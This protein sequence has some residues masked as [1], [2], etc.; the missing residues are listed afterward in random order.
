MVKRLV[1]IDRLK[2]YVD[3]LKIND[4]IEFGEGFNCG[5]EAA[6]CA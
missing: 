3:N 6:L 1:D 4:A 2:F 5:V